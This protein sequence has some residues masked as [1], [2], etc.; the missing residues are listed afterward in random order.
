MTRD[1]LLVSNITI[2]QRY[3]K[4]EKKTKIGRESAVNLP[5]R[6]TTLPRRSQGQ[7]QANAFRSMFT[8]SQ[9]KE[10]SSAH[11]HCSVTSR[12]IAPYRQQYFFPRSTRTAWQPY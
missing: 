6:K 5:I 10:I 1:P 8:A 9:N 11:A 3:F 4:G 7:L 2:K 12:I